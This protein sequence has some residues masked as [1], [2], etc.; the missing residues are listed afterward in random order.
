MVLVSA[1]LIILAYLLVGMPFTYRRMF[2]EEEN[3]MQDFGDEYEE[4]MKRTG[5]IFP[6]LF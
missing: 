5:R 2:K 3:L 1:N 4:Y 6:K